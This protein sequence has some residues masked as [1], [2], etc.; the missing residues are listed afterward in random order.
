MRA[1]NA[2]SSGDAAAAACGAAGKSMAWVYMLDSWKNRWKREF[3]INRPV[4][5]LK[6]RHEASASWCDS[7][8]QACPDTRQTRTSTRLLTHVRELAGRLGSPIG[9]RRC[10]A[11]L[12]HDNADGFDCD[13]AFTCLAPSTTCMGHGNSKAR[14]LAW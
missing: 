4:G 10:L 14:V 1:L 11:R 13:A 6:Q 3:I 8:T 12:S 5:Q 7:T 9:R 2:A